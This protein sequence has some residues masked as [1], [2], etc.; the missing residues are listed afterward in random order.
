MSIKAKY[1][2]AYVITRISNA[3]FH[4]LPMLQ[5][6]TIQAIRAEEINGKRGID[7]VQDTITEIA[8]MAFQ[9][10]KRRV[11]RNDRNSFQIHYLPARRDPADHISYAATTLLGRALR[12]ANWTSEQDTIAA[13]S[14]NISQE[15]T[16]NAAILT[17]SAQ[18]KASWIGL[19]KGKYYAAPA[20]SFI[21][22]GIGAL[23]RH[24]TIGF[25]P[26]ETEPTVDFTRLSDGQKSLLYFSL[27]LAMHSI[28]RKVLK[29]ETDAFDVDKLR[30]AI[31]TLVAL[32][33]PEN[34]LS[35]IISDASSN[36]SR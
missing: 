12:S 4:H 30:P 8:S 10:L 24:L 28:G 9:K 16:N 35:P 21:S 26:G 19:H 2:Q 34:S 7:L 32:E 14:E 31:F 20:V 11:S 17:I 1:L 22:G 5:S 36:V 6:R 33:E 13:L 29:K 27:V 25:S 23:L 3:V 18:I 15:L